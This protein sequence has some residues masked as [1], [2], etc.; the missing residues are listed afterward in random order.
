MSRRHL[1]RRAPCS[2]RAIERAVRHDARPAMLV[3]HALVDAFT[4]RWALGAAPR[5]IA[6]CHQRGTQPPDPW[7]LRLGAD[8]YATLLRSQAD[9]H[10]PA[11]AGQLRRAACRVEEASL[12]LGVELVRRGIIG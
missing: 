12:L 8:T 1:E 4:I 9:H 10:F 11:A 3:R 2:R 6:H 7:D 5:V